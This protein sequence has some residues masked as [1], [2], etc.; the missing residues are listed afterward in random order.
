MLSATPSSTKESGGDVWG[1]FSFPNSVMLYNHM[2]LQYI[3]FF[4]FFKTV[5]TTYFLLFN[6]LSLPGIHEGFKKILVELN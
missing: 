1:P 6:V 3:F 2:L 4:I 5:K